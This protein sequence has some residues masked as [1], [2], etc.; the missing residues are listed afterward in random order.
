M[1]GST[2]CAS[3][4]PQTVAGPSCGVPLPSSTRGPKLPNCALPRAARV[5]VRFSQASGIKLPIESCT[6]PRGGPQQHQQHTCT[7]VYFSQVSGPKLPN[8]VLPAQHAWEYAFRKLQASNSR[9]VYSPAR[10]ATPRQHA[11]EY[12]FRK[13]QA[14]NSRIVYSLA[15]RA[16]P[17]PS[18]MRGSTLFASFR[19]QTAESCDPRA[20]GPSPAARVGVR[21][22]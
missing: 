9:I 13:F 1:R 3:F 22:S 19:P 10:R 4:R 21:F 2:L 6:P 5:G 20:A 17:L 15:W 7:G 11:W 16:P 12:A 8:S 14:P 18:S